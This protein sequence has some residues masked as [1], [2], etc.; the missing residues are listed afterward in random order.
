[1]NLICNWIVIGLNINK[2][3]LQLLGSERSKQ[4]YVHV[5]LFSKV[6]EQGNH[7]TKI[8]SKRT[9]VFCFLT[10]FA[11]PSKAKNPHNT[12]R[13]TRI[14]TSFITHTTIVV[15]GPA[16]W[17]LVQWQKKISCSVIIFKET[18][19]STTCCETLETFAPEI[20]L[21]RKSMLICCPNFLQF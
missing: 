15:I 19:L 2:T 3:N 7:R 5:F 20:M 8:L 13:I 17:R 11:W 14:G 16:N 6:V 4:K 21:G 10:F 1:M 9:F 12:T 18:L